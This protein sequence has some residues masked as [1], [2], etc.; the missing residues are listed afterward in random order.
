MDMADNPFNVGYGEEEEIDRPRL[1]ISR[2]LNLDSNLGDDIF[3]AAGFIGDRNFQNPNDRNFMSYLLEGLADA[4][5]VGDSFRRAR[6]GKVK[7]IDFRNK[8]LKDAINMLPEDDQKI[9]ALSEA[10]FF[11]KDPKTS[12][13]AR[14][15]ALKMRNKRLLEETDESEE[16]AF[17]K[18]ERAQREKE[19]GYKEEQN[20]LRKDQ[21]AAKRI[22]NRRDLFKSYSN[23]QMPFNVGQY[24]SD[25][26]AMGL[27]PAPENEIKSMQLYRGEQESKAL[28]KAAPKNFQ[29]DKEIAQWIDASTFGNM[30]DTQK[31][32]LAKKLRSVREKNQRGQEFKN[33]KN[34]EMNILGQGKHYG[35]EMG[36]NSDQSKLYYKV[37]QEAAKGDKG[38]LQKIMA[39]E[40]KKGSRTYDV[41][42]SFLATLGKNLKRYNNLS[43]ED[44]AKALPWGQLRKYLFGTNSNPDGKNAMGMIEAATTYWNQRQREKQAQGKNVSEN[45]NEDNPAISQSVQDRLN[46]GKGSNLD[47]NDYQISRKKQVIKKAFEKSLDNEFFNKDF[48]Q[49]FPLAE[50]EIKDIK[51]PFAKIVSGFAGGGFRGSFDEF[52]NFSSRF[53]NLNE[54]TQQQLLNFLKSLSEDTS[55]PDRASYG[56]LLDALLKSQTSE[57]E[58]LD[59]DQDQVK[60]PESL[61]SKAKYNRGVIGRSPL[62]SSNDPRNPKDPRELEDIL[63]RLNYSGQGI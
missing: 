53:F 9:L 1:S 54:G 57:G 40:Q 36:L 25:R 20:K 24:Q 43:N 50:K 32:N 18:K 23:Y 22:L 35:K 62:F 33:V 17:K 27:P 26:K 7:R 11:G 48:R 45:K 42:A 37:L 28:L 3:D 60:D 2:A 55:N 52:K 16:L 51:K 8:Q 12:E 56:A 44:K 59:Q 4:G 15:L 46:K 13:S 6:E 10:G 29:N 14:Q 34:F 30:S 19:W 47:S 39:N 31:L 61:T 38:Y 41:A 5:M 58:Q 21:A 49:V 63:N